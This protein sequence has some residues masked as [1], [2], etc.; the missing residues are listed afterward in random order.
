[1]AQLKS[2][3]LVVPATL[4]LALIVGL[5]WFG[6]RHRSHPAPSTATPAAATTPSSSTSAP[7]PESTPSSTPSTTPSGEYPQ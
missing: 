7:A 6:T 4:A 2:S 5:V 1:M 3:S